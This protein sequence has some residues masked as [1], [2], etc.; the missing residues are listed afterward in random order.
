MTSVL[1][2]CD[3]NT[4]VSVMGE[5]ILRSMGHRFAAYSA[6][7]RPAAE[8]APSVLEFLRDRRLPTSGLRAKGSREFLV[9]GAPRLDFVITLSDLAEEEAPTR[10]GGDPVLAHW[11]I[12]ESDEPLT[13]NTVRDAF[14]ALQ[15]RIKIFASLP[16]ASAPRRALQHR[17]E[18]IATWQ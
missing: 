2:V 17:I 10:W 15:R 6:G 1:F 16:L 11:S 7:I 4:A 12:V 9:D 13:G 8:V 18:A 5:S 14:W 3:D